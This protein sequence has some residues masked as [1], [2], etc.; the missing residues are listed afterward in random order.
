VDLRLLHRCFDFALG[1]CLL[2][3]SMVGGELGGWNAAAA[4]VRSDFVVVDAPVGD[5]L[6]CLLQRREP[7]IVEALVAKLAVEAFDVAVLHRLAGLDQQ[8]PNAVPLGHAFLD[9]TRAR[10]F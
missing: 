2:L 8:M 5:D 1:F 4:A 3:L 7:M 9:R 10:P 6:A